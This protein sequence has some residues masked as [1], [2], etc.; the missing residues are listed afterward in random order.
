L[1]I[2]YVDTTYDI[3][4]GLLDEKL[5]WLSFKRYQGQKVSSVLQ[6]ETF[7]MCQEHQLKPSELNAVVTVAGPG[8]YTGLRLSE[9]LADVFT[10]FGIPHYS[11]YSYEV[12]AMLGV[13]SGAWVTKAYRGEYFFHHWSGPD[14]TN[15][16]ISA[17]ELTAHPLA[18]AAYV[19]SDSALDQALL[20][21]F[22]GRIST[23]ELLKHGP[24]PVFTKVL[25]EKMRR[26]SFYFRAPEDEFRV[27]Q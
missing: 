5:E 12:P 11:F 8:F 27:S 13:S 19:H 3:T 17:K 10:F 26:E 9:G 14:S 18:H 25:A 16:L 15:E 2:L 20:D 22:P 4:L 1:A 24:S 23:F 6:L 7:H 21:R